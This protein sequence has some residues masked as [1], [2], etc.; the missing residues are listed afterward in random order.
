MCYSPINIKNPNYGLKFKKGDVRS[1]KDCTS[2]YITVPCGVCEECIAVKQ[3]QITQRIQMEALKHNLYFCTLTYNNETLPV[4]ETSTGFKIRY[5]DIKDVQNMMKRIRKR[6]PYEL[7]YLGVNELGT[8]RGRPHFHLILITKK[9]STP[10]KSDI[11]NQEAEL[12]NLV[13]EEWRRNYGSKRHPE[14]KPLCTYVRKII[15]GEIKTTYDLHYI[16]PGATA[17]GTMNVAFYVSKYMMKPSNRGRRLQQALKL[18]LDE[19]EYEQIWK[20][21][22]NRLFASE[23]LGDPKDEDV[24]KKLKQD[25]A[26]SEGEFAK[27]FN[28]DTGQSFPLSRYYKKFGTI[29]GYDEALKFYNAQHKIG[30]K[31]IDSPHYNIERTSTQ[32]IDMKI[33]RGKRRRKI[34]EENCKDGDFNLLLEKS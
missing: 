6:I 2:H 9:S 20:I 33:E 29:Y 1:F 16:N 28:P 21:I 22:H 24:I 17:D 27:F 3:M 12:F 7:R 5:A 18:N 25:I 8:K 34:V 15:R 14:Y 11:V 4:I 30:T 32:E 23:Y 26:I 19:L 31:D 10:K 13:K